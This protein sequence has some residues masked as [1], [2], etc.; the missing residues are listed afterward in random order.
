MK[1]KKKKKEEKKKK[2]ESQDEM[3]G[4]IGCS[5]SV[6]KHGY[7]AA[8][9]KILNTGGPNKTNCSRFMST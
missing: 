9:I 4:V 2:K 1:R 7:G 3:C 8:K 5:N 6:W